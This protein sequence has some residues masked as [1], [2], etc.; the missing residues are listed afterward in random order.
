MLEES[1]LEFPGALVLVTH[2]RYLLDRVSH[3]ASWPSTA[4]AAR[5]RL[6]RL[7]AVGGTRAGRA[8]AAAAARRAPRPAGASGAAPPRST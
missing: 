3:R 2:D 6:R 5:E 7:R 1:L 4:A 8:A